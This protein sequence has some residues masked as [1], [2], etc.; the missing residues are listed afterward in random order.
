MIYYTLRLNH[1]ENV[2]YLHKLI[3]IFCSFQL[4]IYCSGKQ[5]FI[6]YTYVKGVVSLSHLSNFR[7]LIYIAKYKFSTGETLRYDANCIS[8]YSLLGYISF[9]CYYTAVACKNSHGVETTMHAQIRGDN[10]KFFPGKM[11]SLRVK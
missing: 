5:S 6:Y 1:S 9:H 2:A 8:L 10:L 4:I 7:R 3:L 11:T